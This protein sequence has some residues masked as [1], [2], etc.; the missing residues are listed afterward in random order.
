M[1]GNLFD[2]KKTKFYAVHREKIAPVVEYEH[3]IGIENISTNAG[4]KSIRS[5]EEAA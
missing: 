3:L 4:R 1:D 5:F 2:K